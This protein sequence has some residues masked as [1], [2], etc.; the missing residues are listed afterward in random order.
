MKPRCR[1]QSWVLALP[2]APQQPG[3]AQATATRHW[4]G[5]WVLF[6]G[7]PRFTFASR[8]TGLSPKPPAPPDFSAVG[9]G[10][11]PAH[12]GA[13]PVTPGGG[14]TAVT[15]VPPRFFVTQW[16]RSGSRERRGGGGDTTPREG[17]GTGPARQHPGPRPHKTGRPPRAGPPRGGVSPMSRPRPS[18]SAGSPPASN[19]SGP[20]RPVLPSRA[21]KLGCQVWRGGG[22]AGTPPER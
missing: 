13:F 16:S 3:P 15:P 10:L 2:A 20:P 19:G 5:P 21:G 14:H 17:T 22:S 18:H 11:G 12:A 7:V 8:V 6:S 4:L 1:Q 9:D